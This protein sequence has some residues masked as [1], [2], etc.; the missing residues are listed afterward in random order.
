M[1]SLT[2]AI[3]IQIDSETKRKATDILNDLGLSMSTAINI[4]L[5]QVIKKDGLPFEVNNNS[6]DDLLDAIEEIRD[7]INNPQNYPSYTNREDLKKAL[8]K[9]D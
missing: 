8:L 4:F 3:N 7:M 9:D 2:S 5:R 1:A 6:N